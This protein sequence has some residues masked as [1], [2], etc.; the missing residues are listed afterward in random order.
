MLLAEIAQMG[1]PQAIAIAATM[2]AVA[3]VLGKAMSS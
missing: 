1:W 2:F 3:Y